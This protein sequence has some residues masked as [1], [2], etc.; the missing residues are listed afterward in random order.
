ML[1]ELEAIEQALTEKRATFHPN[2]VNVYGEDYYALRDAARR[3]VRLLPV[4]GEWDE[5]LVGKCLA[6]WFGGVW[7]PGPK[8]D[9]DLVRRMSAVL[10]VIVEVGE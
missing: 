2:T 8:D 1:M 5:Q 3:F 6:A 9:P 7:H 10:A 4:D